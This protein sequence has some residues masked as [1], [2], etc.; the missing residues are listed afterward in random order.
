MPDRRRAY[1]RAALEAEFAKVR[2]APVG[3]RN[4][5]LNRAAF[6]LARLDGL[7]YDKVAEGLLAIAQGWGPAEHAKARTTIRSAFGARG[8]RA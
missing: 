7:H 8:V 5:T 6:A 1:L 4:D 3:T 2:N